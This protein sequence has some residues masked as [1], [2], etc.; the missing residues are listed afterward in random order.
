MKPNNY[1]NQ[2]EIIYFEYKPKGGGLDHWFGG[3]TEHEASDIW[4]INRDNG[5]DYLHPT[6]KPVEL[7]SRAISN[8]CPDQ[9]L[10]F[11]P[12]GGS[13]STFVAAHQ[14]HRRCFGIEID[15]KY[16]QVILDRMLKLDPTLTI[17]RNGK[18]YLP[19]EALAKEG[20]PPF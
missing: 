15:P 13:G 9:G 20:T 4:R 19:A 3:R 7:P 16:C 10:V 18:K 11:E 12:F 6:Q 17:T 1:H 2:Y 8:S 5:N 14:L